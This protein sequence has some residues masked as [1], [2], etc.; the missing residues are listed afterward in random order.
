MCRCEAVRFVSVLLLALAPQVVAVKDA[1]A[2]AMVLDYVAHYDCEPATA[3]HLMSVLALAGDQA[4]VAGNQGLT[5]VDL[6]ALPPGGDYVYIHRLGG[7]NARDIYTADGQWFFVNLHRTGSGGSGGSAVVERVGDELFHRITIDQPGILFEKMCLEGGFLYVAAHAQGVR[8]YD[9]AVPSAPALVGSLGVGF[10][11]AFAT[12]VDGDLL[13]VAD[14]AGG[15]KLVDI[16][17]P[18]APAHAGGENLLSASGTAEAVTVH[19]GHVYVAAGGAGV[20]FYEGGDPTRRTLYPVGGAAEEM[21]WWGDYL[22]VSDFGAVTVYAAQPDGSLVLVAQEYV[23]R[24]YVDG[25]ARLRLS[26]GLDT[27]PDGRVLCANWNDMDVYQ[28]L[29]EAAGTQADLSVDTRRIRFPAT[30][31]AANVT[32]RNNGAQTLVI[33]A[34]TCDDS[35]FVCDYLGGPLSPGESLVCEVTYDGTGTSAGEDLLFHSN[36]PDEDPLPIQVFGR[37]G[38]LDPGE[39]ATGF[40]LPCWGKDAGGVWNVAPFTLSDH[41]GKIVWFQ[42]YGSW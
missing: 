35:A 26:E 11:D 41:L 17:D 40:S 30:G 8:V 24:R 7:L 15:L 9:V 14:G 28:L 1:T 20:A 42:I 36:D 19:A 34:V 13:Y 31:G 16:S 2:Q 6:A 39:P 22:C 4:I 21:C 10:T 38:F 3:D 18:A 29:P 23:Q 5:L 25:S 32:L 33:S 27:T 12:A 37:T